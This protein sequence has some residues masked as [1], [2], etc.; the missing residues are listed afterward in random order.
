M[1]TESLMQPFR[2]VAY[3]AKSGADVLRAY[4]GFLKEIVTLPPGEWNEDTLLPVIK[5]HEEARM[6]CGGLCLW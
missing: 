6:R 1:N 5:E 4:N 2:S 3:N